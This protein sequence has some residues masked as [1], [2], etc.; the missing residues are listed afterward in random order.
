MDKGEYI[1]LE[2]LENDILSQVIIPEI[3]KPRIKHVQFFKWPGSV[4][5]SCCVTLHNCHQEL[6]SY[7][8]R[9]RIFSG[10]DK[11]AM[12]LSFSNTFEA[13]LKEVP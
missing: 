11:V 2:M 10:L 3:L 1:T 9:N 12:E 7:C 5:V 4:I 6:G 8:P 13:L